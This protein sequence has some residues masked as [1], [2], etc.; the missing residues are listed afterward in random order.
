MFK[1]DQ[2]AQSRLV[3]LGKSTLV[4]AELLFGGELINMI[5]RWPLTLFK[6]E[7]LYVEKRRSG[8]DTCHT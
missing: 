4:P 3:P 8:R 2:P 5:F 7:R 6:N 1:Q